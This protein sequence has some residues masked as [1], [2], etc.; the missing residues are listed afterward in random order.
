ML[1]GGRFK[2]ELHPKALK[3]SSSL[4]VDIELILEDIQG[5]KAHAQ[6]L[7]KVK[8]ITQS[9]KKEI[10][11]GLIRIEQDWKEGKWIPD[12]GKYEDIH[13]AIESR[14]FELIGETAGKLHT[15]RSRNDQIAL[16]LKLWI[17]KKTDALPKLIKDLQ[18]I[19]VDLAS[20]NIETIIPGY[21]HLQRA[22]PVSLAFH[23]LAYVEMLER[24]LSRLEFI[25]SSLNT[26][27]LGAGALAGSTLP[28]DRDFTSTMLGFD[29]PSNN[30][31]DSVSDRD[32]VID[33]LNASTIGMMHLS[34]LSEEIILWSSKEWSFIELGDEVS[35]GSSLM[36]QKKNP[37]L[38]ELIRGKTGKVYGNYI[39]FAAVMKGLPLSYNRDMQ[40][41]KEP[42]FNSVKIYS[43]S[44]EI[45]TIILKNIRIYKERFNKELSGDFSV[46]TDLAEWLVLKGMPFREAHIIIGNI[47]KA[48]E[49]KTKDFKDV[50]LEFLK[51][52][53]PL[54]DKESLKYLD[55]NTALSKK[56]TKGS[57][58]PELVKDQIARWKNKLKS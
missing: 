49:E 53:S 50:N 12:P 43:E 23:F 22:Q 5:S 14:L 33:T 24:D 16:D 8:I 26:S 34:R 2:K 51:K 25:K 55:I 41:D 35:T 29:S 42:L 45:M 32:F 47:I 27:P 30:A 15:G 54:F 20:G 4:D 19:L 56:K 48:L 36:P 38:A 46:A 58:N 21:T 18:V 37:D 1:W 9:E 52:F 39:S 17:R 10:L 13:S 40:E 28:L 57:P 31:L 11:L 7:S 3:F 44:L 6:M